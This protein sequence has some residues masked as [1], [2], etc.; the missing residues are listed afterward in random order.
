M[1]PVAGIGGPAALKGSDDPN[2]VSEARLSGSE[3][4]VLERTGI[5]IEGLADVKT[6]I[7]FV[8]Y[9]GEMGEAALVNSVHQ[10]KVIG[11]IG[12]HATSNKDTRRAVELLQTE[13]VDIILFAG[14]DGTA[15]DI[16]DV[17][18]PGQIVLGIPC[19]VKMHSGVFANSPVAAGKS[20]VILP[21]ENSPP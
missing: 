20:S 4:K 19:G 3:S 13:S 2:L 8:A 7:E 16:C 12:Q 18:K 1:N 9:S 14:G 5:T 10:Y 11:E 21:W 17:I 15:G 6:K